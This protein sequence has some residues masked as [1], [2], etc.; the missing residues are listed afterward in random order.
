MLTLTDLLEHYALVPADVR[1]VRHGNKELPVLET[2]RTNLKRFEAYQSFQLPNR[3][4][5]GSF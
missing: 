5:C 2:F 4:G 1:L 3:F